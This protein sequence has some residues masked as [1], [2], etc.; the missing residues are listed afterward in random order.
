MNADLRL[1]AV[2]SWPYFRRSS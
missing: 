1:Y 2:I